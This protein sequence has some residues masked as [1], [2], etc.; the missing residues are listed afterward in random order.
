M[1]QIHLQSSGKT[2]RPPWGS[3]GPEA[4]EGERIWEFGWDLLSTPHTEQP[5]GPSAR[6]AQVG[7]LA[8][9]TLAQGR[10]QTALHHSRGK[11]KNVYRTKQG[12]LAA[13]KS[14]GLPPH[15][16]QECLHTKH[17][18]LI[19]RGTSLHCIDQVSGN[20]HI[21]ISWFQSHSLLSDLLPL[22]IL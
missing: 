21:S 5:K 9:G 17:I 6:Q 8:Q 12:N 19:T 1:K 20:P 22:Y 3:N 16:N 4:K 18:Y 15:M 7:T 14:L 2:E 11:N 10:Q 13:P